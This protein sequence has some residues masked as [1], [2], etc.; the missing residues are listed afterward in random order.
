MSILGVDISTHN[1]SVNFE[2]LK[3]SV[4]FVICRAG[5]GKENNQVDSAF[6]RNVQGCQAS[7]I[8]MAVYWYSYADTIEHSL[9]EANTCY[10]IIKNVKNIQFVAYDMEDKIQVNLNNPELTANMANTF[11]DF[12]KSKGYKTKFYSYQSFINNSINLNTV[13][14]HSHG[15]WLAYYNGNPNTANHS[16]V[17]DIWQYSSSGSVSGITGRVDMNV[18]YN[19]A[20]FGNSVVSIDTTALK[21]SSHCTY[22]FKIT[23][24]SKPQFT[25]AN[26][27]IVSAPVFV[28][29]AGNDYFY[30]VTGGNMGTVGMYVNG[31]RMCIV[32]VNNWPVISDTPFNFN[33]HKGETYQYKLT[34]DAMPYVTGANSS[35]LKIQFNGN[36][37]KDYFYKVTALQLCAGVGL[38]ANG[39]RISVVT[40]K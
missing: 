25:S 7:N 26:N 16:N 3:K 15:L 31:K 23:A 38:Y 1:G 2:E 19:N 11:L 39:K 36:K 8:P 28:S 27:N 35:V 24:S 4:S 5:Y 32:Q 37:G 30:K 20:L 9:Q 29:Q 22:Q 12:F 33:M 21:L 17:A 13:K 6:Y 14:A 34:C 18:C 10:N 40:I